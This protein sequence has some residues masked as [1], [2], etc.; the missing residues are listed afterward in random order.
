[1]AVKGTIAKEVAK[2]YVN[3]YSGED[4]KQLEIQYKYII[5]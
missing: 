4:K 2:E 1:M 5:N 3:K